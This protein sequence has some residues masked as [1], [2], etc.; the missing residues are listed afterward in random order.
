MKGLGFRGLRAYRVEDFMEFRKGF[1]VVGSPDEQAPNSG[2][3]GA[4]Q[5]NLPVRALVPPFAGVAAAGIAAVLDAWERLAEPPA[6]VAGD[7]LAGVDACVLSSP[8]PTKQQL[9]D[10]LQPGKP[11]NVQPALMQAEMRCR[12]IRTQFGPGAFD[13]PALR[14]GCMYKI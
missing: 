14:A 1:W 2:S 13:V 3:D 9:P 7:F 8:R 10:R 5:A 11:R 4:V 12:W 6:A